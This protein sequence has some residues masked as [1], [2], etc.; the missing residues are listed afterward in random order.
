[1]PCTLLLSYFLYRLK[2]SELTQSY[3]ESPVLTI[4]SQS[5]FH[6]SIKQCLYVPAVLLYS[7]LFYEMRLSGFKENKLGM[8]IIVCMTNGD[9]HC[10]PIFCSHVATRAIFLLIKH[11]EAMLFKCAFFKL[12]VI[13]YHNNWVYKH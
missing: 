4:E 13:N 7:M 3:A 11:S 5:P 8:W 12:S 9:V 6:M 1:M 2:N 10:S